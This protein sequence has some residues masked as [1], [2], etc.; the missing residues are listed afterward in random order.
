MNTPLPVKAT[1]DPSTWI[2]RAKNVFDI[3]IDSME[4]TREQIGDAFLEAVHIILATLE[5]KGRIVLTG[6]GKN[7]PIAEKIAATMASTG[8]TSFV[9]NPVQ[10]MHGDLGMLMDGDCIIALSFSGESEEV[11]RLLPFIRRRGLPVIGIAGKA[12]ST[13]EKDCNVLL[14]V[15][16]P[17][18]ACPFNMAPTASTTVT[19]ALGDALAMVVMDARGFRKDEYARFHPAGA[20]GKTLLLRV[21]DIMRTGKHVARLSPDATVKDAIVAMTKA[22]AGSACIVGEGDELIGIFTDGDMRRCL[23]TEGGEMLQ[24][25]LADYM[26]RQPIR[27]TDDQMAA[28]VLAIF[29]SHRIDDLPVVDNKGR[30]VGCID[31]QDLPKLKML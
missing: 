31:S 20:I 11:V 28:A 16:T 12:G 18:E 6:I 22:Q 7:V 2:A 24:R 21:T 8:T 10:A 27:T 14:K 17:R 23:S 30:L 19:L 9:L 25:P 26:T 13:M 3:E 5:R 29:T 4:R 1:A 15:D